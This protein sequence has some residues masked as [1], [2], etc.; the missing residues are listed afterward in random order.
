MRGICH[1]SRRWHQQFSL[2]PSFRG[3]Q[4]CLQSLQPVRHLR[5]PARS[6]LPRSPAPSSV[7]S[8][9]P[10][11]VNEYEQYGNDASTRVKVHDY[12]AEEGEQMRAQLDE[13]DRDLALMKEG[14]FGPNSEF[15]QSFPPDERE[16]LLK[17]LEEEGVM[18]PDIDD[19]LTAEDLEEVARDEKTSRRLAEEK[20]PLKVTLS[21][22]SKDKIYVKRFNKVLHEA[23][24]SGAKD[25]DYFTLWKWYLRCQQHVSNFAV[26]I[27][28]DVWHFL[29]KTQTTRFYRPKHLAMLGK[30]MIRVDVQLEDQELVQYIDALEDTG[31]IAAAAETWEAQKSRLGNNNEL[32]ETF[33]TTGIRIYVALGKPQKA[34]N[35]A[36]ECY[37]HTTMVDPEVLVMVISAWAKSQRESAPT[38]A[39]SCYLDLRKRLERNEDEQTS[40][41]VLGRVS[42]ALLEAGRTELASAVFKDMYLLKYKSAFDSWTFFQDMAKSLP[43]SASPGE[44]IVNKIGL[45]SLAFLPRNFYNRFFFGSWIKWLI[46]EGR[47]DEAAQVVELMY[48]RGTRPDARHL[49]GLVAAWL[50]EGSPTSRKSAED[51]AWAMIRE[52]VEMVKKRQAKTT[53]SNPSS[54]KERTIDAAQIPP[55]LR[56]GAPAATIETF[57]ILL[58]HYTRRSDLE[59]ASRVTDV[60][61]GPAQMKPNAFIMNHWLYASLRSGQAEEVWTRYLNLKETISPDLETFCA[62]WDTAKACYTPPNSHQNA[63]P[64]A[65]SLFAEM[66]GWLRVIEPRRR[67]LVKA[68]FS[69][70]LYEQ[71]IRCF[72]LL[73][74]PNGVLCALYGLRESFGMLPHEEVI[75]LII[76]S[77][78]RSFWSDFV[79]PQQRRASNMRKMK[80]LHYQSAVKT[81]TEIIVTMMDRKL[82]DGDMDPEQIEDIESKPAQELRFD[83]LT[84]FLCMVVEKRSKGVSDISEQVSAVA[85]EMKASVSQEIFI[86]RDW[87]KM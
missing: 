42:G 58:Q 48:E 55:F 66:Q 84:S 60:M 62:L 56:R 61:L 40:L 24:Q 15:I 67:E 20:D 30:D 4:T 78:A 31:D 23:G 2:S 11:K 18:A 73:S 65:R 22:P 77:V 50:R 35:L 86:R 38:K 8:V 52:R 43:N 10:V 12:L 49:N 29:W 13:L 41:R 47:L 25:K 59:N 27:P 80:H 68:D 72:C 57:S 28:E 36:F 5:Q 53:I 79:G 34:Q 83:V 26:I 54:P 39:W 64:D 3:H 76:V 46:G 87:D 74:D 82:A 45:A 6:R 44:D 21:I 85:Q 81:L 75:R 51:T 69:P 7:P 32:A 33:W 1:L 63:F 9:A 37:D 19:M 71:I 70:E 16:E 17:A 14:P